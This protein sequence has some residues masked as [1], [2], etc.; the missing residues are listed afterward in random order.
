VV[1]CDTSG[2]LAAFDVSQHHSDKAAAALASAAPPRVISPFVVAELDYMVRRALGHDAARAVFHRVTS[3]AYELPCLELSDLKRALGIDQFH[4]DLGI[5]IADASLVVLAD[6]Y[7]TLDLLTFDQRHFRKVT[8]IQGGSF[9][10]LP[11]DG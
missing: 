8:P 4:A 7:N 1:I 2:L 11:L 9:R 3:G 5:G 6:R 10:L